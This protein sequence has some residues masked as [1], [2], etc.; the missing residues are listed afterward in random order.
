[1]RIVGRDWLG[2]LNVAESSL[3]GL[4]NLELLLLLLYKYGGLFFVRGEAEVKLTGNPRTVTG[5]GT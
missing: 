5:Q 1:M 3:E 2:L 4:E